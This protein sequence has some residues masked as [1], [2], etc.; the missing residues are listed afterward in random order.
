MAA[1]KSR[2]TNIPENNNSCKLNDLIHLENDSDCVTQE[3]DLKD[4]ILGKQ[5]LNSD[6]MSSVNI[7]LQQAGY[8]VNGF[9]DTMLAPVL[10]KNGTWQ[11]PAEGFKS[12]ISPSTNIYYNSKNHWVTSFQFE[13]G[14]VYL[15]DSDL[16]KK[17]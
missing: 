17:T 7:L 1:K 15:L 3:R 6:H 2:N 16:G 13:G 11:T 12:Q 10:K 9:Q 14:D 8:S 4:S 5:W